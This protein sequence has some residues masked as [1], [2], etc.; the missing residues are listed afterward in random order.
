[1]GNSPFQTGYGQSIRRSGPL[2]ALMD[3][4]ER[5]TTELKERIALLPLSSYTELVGE[6]EHGLGSIRIVIMNVIDNGFLFANMLRRR[7]GMPEFSHGL[8][9]ETPELAAMSLNAM[10]ACTEGALSE[11][12]ELDDKELDTVHISAAWGTDYTLAQL[13]EHAI[14]QVLR[15]RRQVD[16]YLDLMQDR[17]VRE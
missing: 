16:H 4:Y 7:F 9:A 8:R 3:E 17:R 10:L 2:G 14:V 13:I 1:M 12:W 6:T 15:Q 5:S 11:H